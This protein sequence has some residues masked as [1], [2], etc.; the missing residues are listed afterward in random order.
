MSK[1][2]LEALMP[3]CED[4]GVELGM[5]IKALRKGFK[6]IEVPTTMGHKETGRDLLGFIHRGKQFMDVIKVLLA[7][8]RNGI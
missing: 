5:T 4:Y 6:V 2:V 7:I 8:R 3:F 1:D